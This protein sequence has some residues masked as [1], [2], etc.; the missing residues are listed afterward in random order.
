MQNTLVLKCDVLHA[1][2]LYIII[3]F[4]LKGFKGRFKLWE[5]VMDIL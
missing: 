1:F 2:E 4:I 5:H 3:K